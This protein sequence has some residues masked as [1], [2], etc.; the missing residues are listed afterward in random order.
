[1]QVVILWMFLLLYPAN[2]DP[3]IGD[4]VTDNTSG[5]SLNGYV[6]N[7]PMIPIFIQSTED[8][9]G[10][11]YK[12]VESFRFSE[13]LPRIIQPDTLNRANI[14]WI[15]SS[16]DEDRFARPDTVYFWQYE[17]ISSYEMAESDSTLRWVN[18][19]NLFDRFHQEHG[20]VTYRMGTVG[21]V[22]GVELHAFE[23][24]HMSLELEGMHFNDPLTGAVNW[25]RLP[26]HKIS[27]MV[28]ADYG[29]TYRAKTRLRD[30]YLVQPRTYLNFDESK[31]NHRSLE[32]SFT[33]NFRNTTNLELS[34]WDRRDGGGYN[35]QEIEGRQ[36]FARVY[37]QLGERWL[38]KGAYIDNSIDRQEPFGYALTDPAL[39]PFN[40][41]ITSPLQSNASSVQS[42]KDIYLQ[43]HHRKDIHEAV[44]SKMGLHVQT[45]QYSLTSSVDT[46]ATDFKRMELFARQYVDL[47][48]IELAGTAR[49][50]FLNEREE[51]NLTEHQWTGGELSL[52]LNRSLF[53]IAEIDGEARWFTRNDAGSSGEISGR[54]S[55]EPFGGVRFSVFGGMLSRAPDIQ[56]MYWRS[57]LY[58]GN[59]SLNHENSILTGVK[60]EFPITSTFSAGLRGDHRR[61]ENAAFV[62]GEGLFTEIDPY[63]MLSGTGWIE[64]HSERFEG[65]LSATF[66]QF[67]TTASNDINM[68]LANA[69][70]R[71]WVKGSFY[72]KNYLFDNAT[73]V[74]AG[75]S[76]VYSPNPFRTAEFMTP[77]NRWQHGTHDLVNP[78]YYRVDVDVSARVRWFM[79]LLKWENIFDR[80]QQPGYFE[81]VGYPMPE[82]RFR[83]GIRVL[84]TN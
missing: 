42:S 23:S 37:H 26:V 2:S 12:T 64:H 21:R 45:D 84:F 83:F 38:V 5:M 75:V 56:S 20:A 57:T 63:D 77:L 81:T 25:N 71:I 65:D 82:R 30:H 74:K 46:V 6:A 27:E 9:T 54:F 8:T 41:F 43:I 78:S 67:S 4:S 61:T 14:R 18:M 31:F 68:K 69:G 60:L 29:A 11:I 35:R 28:D 76:G 49:A 19:L 40:R 48:G 32:F 55:V 59:E 13:G 62:N 73:F 15:G 47:A 70:D 80:V 16:E 58:S 79:V 50:Y 53:R 3:V 7:E 51:V 36:V 33:Q 44:S 10:L 34:F 22:D 66:K 24:R 72:W 1:M 17:E 52:G 39:F